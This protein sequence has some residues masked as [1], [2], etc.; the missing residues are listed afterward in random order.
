[1]IWKRIIRFSNEVLYCS[2]ALKISST[3]ERLGA[4]LGRSCDVLGFV[5]NRKQEQT[6][7]GKLADVV[8]GVLMDWIHCLKNGRWATNH[9]V[10]LWL[11]FLP[12]NKKPKILIS[13]WI[14]KLTTSDF[15]VFYF[16]TLQSKSSEISLWALLIRLLI[17]NNLLTALSL[18]HTGLALFSISST[19]APLLN[20]QLRHRDRKSLCPTRRRRSQHTPELPGEVKQGG[21]VGSK[22]RQGAADV[23]RLWLFK[24]RAQIFT[25]VG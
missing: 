9:Q 25:P 1:M 10:Y 20:Q 15:L 13:Y 12:L 3:T 21:R 5:H 4:K 17:L 8:N 18:F 22:V 2:S 16:L 19:L 11:V 24:V 7:R 14:Q 23:H 6:K